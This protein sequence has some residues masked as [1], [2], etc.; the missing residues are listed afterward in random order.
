MCA[1]LRLNRVP[2]MKVTIDSS[3][4]LE[5]AIRVLGAMYDVTLSVASQPSG[6]AP[7][8]RSTG[9]ADSSPASNRAAASKTAPARAST[10]RTRRASKT[11]ATVV[12]ASDLRSWA[13]AN[14]YDVR[15]YGRVP[16]AVAKAYREAHQS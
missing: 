11:P 14:G 7:T 15:S 6:P 5:N 4:P 3:E 2:I 10:R 9:K 1:P 13:R 8:S 16:V 12:S